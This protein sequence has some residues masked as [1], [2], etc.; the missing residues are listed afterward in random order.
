VEKNTGALARLTG[1][2]TTFPLTYSTTTSTEQVNMDKQVATINLQAGQSE[3]P[4]E[5]DI[6]YDQIF[7]TL[8]ATRGQPL[9][10]QPRLAGNITDES[11]VP[12]ARQR[13][14]LMAGGKTYS[15]FSDAKGDFRFPFQGI[16]QGSATL[17]VGKYSQPVTLTGT[18]QT[19]LKLKV[20][21]ALLP[22]TRR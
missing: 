6:F 5:V 14:A 7:G 20:R 8:V 13:L 3:T 22:A 17:A 18:P 12:V 10:P 16:A 2:D 15:V 11:G 21:R 9:A 1:A 19:Q 4:F